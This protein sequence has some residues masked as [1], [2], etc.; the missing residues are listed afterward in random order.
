[1]SRPKQDGYTLLE[2][3]IVVVIVGILAAIA[4]PGYTAYLY[5]SRAAEAPLFL[6]EIRQRQESYRAEFGT[7]A[8]CDGQWSPRAAGSVNATQVV[9]TPTNNCWRQLAAA[10]DGPVRFAYVFEAGGPGDIGALGTAAG[11]TGNDFYFVSQ[12]R[13]DLNADGTSFFFEGYSD[14]AQLYVSSTRGWE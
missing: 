8:D 13:G 10:P 14:R 6:S 3:M 1:M 4:I 2:L 12:A 11:A 9:W 5:R 7:Y